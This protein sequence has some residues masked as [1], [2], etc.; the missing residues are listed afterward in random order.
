MLDGSSSLEKDFYFQQQKE[1]RRWGRAINFAALLHIAIFAGALYLPGFFA[2]KPLLDDVMTIDLVSLPEPAGNSAPEPSPAAEQKPV[3]KTEP[4]PPPPEPEKAVPVEPAEPVVSVAEPEPPP[5]VESKPISVR[6]LKRKIRKAKDTRLVEE[7]EQQQ[8]AK[9]LKRQ[10]LAKQLEQQER[11]KEL[12]RQRQKKEAA[13]QRALANARSEEKRAQNAARQARDEL[14]SVIREQQTFRSTG[15]NSGSRS[16]SSGKKQ[17]NSIVEKQ[18]YIDLSRRVQQLWVLPEMRQWS[19]SLVTIVEF[20]VLKDG[21]LVNLTVAKSSG[22]SFFDRFARESVRKA[23]PMPP[24][25][26][27]LGKDR[28]ELGLRLSPGGIQR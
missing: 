5:V 12:K 28:L 17:V 16:K 8:R 11:A 20:T 26:A 1:D 13:R 9:K 3:V 15:T 14:A 6:P 22:D 24:F 25:P 10:K 21:R 19:S 23:A 2:K 18:Y 7:I 27:V 4:T